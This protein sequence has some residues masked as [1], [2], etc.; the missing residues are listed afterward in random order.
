MRKWV[1]GR[2]QHGRL[3][4]ASWIMGRRASSPEAVRSHQQEQEIDIDAARG[5]AG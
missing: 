5:M 4:A 1:D 2:L 3:G